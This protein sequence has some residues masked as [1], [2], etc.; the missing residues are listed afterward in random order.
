VGNLAVQHNEERST[1]DE[2]AVPV[3]PIAVK[4]RALA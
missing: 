2:A 3:Y 4:S 1:L